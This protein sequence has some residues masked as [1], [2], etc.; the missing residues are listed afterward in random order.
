M[1]SS[2]IYSGETMLFEVYPKGKK[3]AV[4]HV[5]SQADILG[6]EGPFD[7]RAQAEVFAAEFEASPFIWYFDDRRDL[8]KLNKKEEIFAFHTAARAKA[9]SVK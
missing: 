8:M 9:E 4:R 1:L 3:W 2:V 7:S 5:M 6:P